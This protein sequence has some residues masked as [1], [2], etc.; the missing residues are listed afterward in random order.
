M[1]KPVTSLLNFAASGVFWSLLQVWMNRFF[2]LIVSIIL[3]RL[4]TPTDFGIASAG[5]LILL[6]IPIIAE[7]GFT[8][9]IIQRPDLKSRDINLPFFVSLGACVLATLVVAL[10]ADWISRQ[11][12]SEEAATYIS[13]VVAVALLSVPNLLQ[14]GVYKRN[15]EFKRLA[16][17][18]FWAKILAGCLAVAAA[19]LGASYWSFLVQAY[20]SV[21]ITTVIMW[22]KAPWTPRLE[23]DIISFKEMFRFGISVALQKMNSFLGT[24][25]IDFVILAK[26]GLAAYGI[27]SVGARL[28]DF[29][30]QMLQGALGDV[31]LSALSKISDDTARIAAIY[32]KTI[33]VSAYVI[34][35]IFILMSSL[36]LEITR[37]LFGEKWE[38][39]ESISSI[40]MALGAVNAVQFMGGNFLSARGKPN[41]ILVAGVVKTVVTLLAIFFIP[42]A[43][44]Y[45]MTVVFLIAQLSA[46]PI[47]FYMVSRELK[48][49]QGNIL[50]LLAPAATIMGLCF[51]A[52]WYL[53]AVLTSFELPMLLQ[54]AILGA[55]FIAVYACCM[56]IAK[57]DMTLLGFSKLRAM[58]RNI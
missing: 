39:V 29:L 32:L 13:L 20:V 46:T 3:A 57:R 17:L 19:I 28:F 34:S 30:Q 1:Q 49:S 52:V 23:F 4:L 33:S 8:H 25:L 5:S 48:I 12:G 43:N 37:V 56:L 27:F 7:L 54:G 10:N 42:T 22:R 41:M 26:F 11:L 45:E 55:S 2:T 36:S 18:T 53:R 21:I 50:R 15:M 38:G 9:A 6:L 24:K 35:P 44:I 51:T 40:L 14:Q 58:I 47:S 31:S 16:I